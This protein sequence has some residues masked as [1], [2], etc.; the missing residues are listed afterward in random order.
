MKN[1][2][3][4]GSTRWCTFGLPRST[5]R[6][7][8]NIHHPWKPRCGF[9]HSRAKQSFLFKPFSF[10]VYMSRWEE[11]QFNSQPWCF[12]WI[13]KQQ[14]HTRGSDNRSYSLYFHLIQTFIV[15]AAPGVRIDGIFW[16][17]S[18]NFIAVFELSSAFKT[19][20]VIN[21]SQVKA[22]KKERRTCFCFAWTS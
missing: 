3:S 12:V 7:W 6:K 9:S 15:N 1:G 16:E 14:P 20:N 11:E 2:L 17:F 13:P 21:N 10:T 19:L 22:I 4:S 5:Y 8:R 18:Y